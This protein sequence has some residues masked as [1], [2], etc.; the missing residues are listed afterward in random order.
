M[1]P[2]ITHWFVL[3]CATP[4]RPTQRTVLSDETGLVGF[5]PTQWL[6][7]NQLPYRLA[8]AQ[9]CHN[10][11]IL[12]VTIIILLM[13]AS[14]CSL[15]WRAYWF[16]PIHLF[17]IS[18]S[19]CDTHVNYISPISNSYIE[20]ISGDHLGSWIIRVDS[21]IASCYTYNEINHLL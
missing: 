18:N 16:N 15:F 7:Q 21:V 5:E 20:G 2:R 1:H 6:D 17:S 10:S 9:D 11:Y 13:R 19:I 4:S 3:G 14:L 8:I 12:I